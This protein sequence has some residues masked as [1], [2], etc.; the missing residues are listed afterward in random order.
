VPRGDTYSSLDFPRGSFVTTRVHPGPM[1]VAG[2]DRG[3]G[4]LSFFL[5]IS[6]TLAKGTYSS[7][8]IPLESF[9]TTRVH[10]GPTFVAGLG[11][12]FGTNVS[13]LFN[14]VP[15][16]VRRSCILACFLAP[17]ALLNLVPRG[18]T[19]SSLDFPR[20]SFVTT[21]VHPGPMFVAGL[22]CCSSGGGF[23]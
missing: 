4:S 2:S 18:D 23:L 16:F 14:V 1:F 13:F 7:L 21:R 12:C 19:Y 3:I 8:K 20:G 10:W 6:S 5:T 17:A 15:P 9:V 22:D 11:D